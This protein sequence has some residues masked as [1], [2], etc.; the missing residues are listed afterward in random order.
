MN[1][2]QP[3]VQVRVRKRSRFASSF[4]FNSADRSCPVVIYDLTVQ[5]DVLDYKLASSIDYGQKLSC[6]F[7]VHALFAY[8]IGILLNLKL[9]V[10]G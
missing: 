5:T 4:A 2:P 10:L 9:F 7:R 3:V 1:V 8:L 6:L